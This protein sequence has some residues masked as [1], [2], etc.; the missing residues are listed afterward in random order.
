MGD[1]DCA[2]EVRPRGMVARLRTGD[3]ASAAGGE[4]RSGSGVAGIGRR[5][6]RGQRGGARGVAALAGGTGASVGGLRRAA[7]PRLAGAGVA[8]RHSEAA[9]EARGRGDARGM[10][11]MV[12][13]GGCEGAE[14]ARARGAA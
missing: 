11:G 1:G 4:G 9:G 14:E 2:W 3:G 12:Q 5:C 8:R 13:E 7:W 6:W 10:V